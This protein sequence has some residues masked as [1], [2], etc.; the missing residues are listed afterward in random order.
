ML[1]VC[2]YTYN[3]EGITR[4][5]GSWN[6]K[7]K[8]F[9]MKNLTCAIHVESLWLKYILFRVLLLASEASH[10]PD[11]VA[12]APGRETPRASCSRVLNS[13]AI[14]SMLHTSP[15]RW[16]KLRC[17]THNPSLSR[18]SRSL[19]RP[20]QSSHCSQHYSSGPGH[21]NHHAGRQT[22]AT[23]AAHA[24]STPPPRWRLRAQRNLNAARH[25]INNK[26]GFK[27]L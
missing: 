23:K 27:V 14:L 24:S 3:W 2:V 7:P 17:A 21:H 1:Y 4:N 26:H 10:Q 8:N 20:T 12:D 11:K 9:E 22:R 5:D 19:Q 6:T 25:I 15:D 13:L 18:S 16:R